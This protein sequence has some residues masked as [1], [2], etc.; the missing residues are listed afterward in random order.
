MRAT[1]YNYFRDYD[2]GIGRYVESDPI[3][4]EG[5]IN[6][7]AYVKGNP[8]NWVDPEGLV[9]CNGKWKL[10]NRTYAKT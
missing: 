8:V 6:T 5:G 1:C 7:Y 9:T 3:G 4:L 2:P 10:F